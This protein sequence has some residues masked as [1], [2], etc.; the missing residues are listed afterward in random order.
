MKKVNFIFKFF[1]SPE[2]SRRIW[3]VSLFIVLAAFMSVQDSFAGSKNSRRLAMLRCKQTNPLYHTIIL[4]AAKR[5]DVEP[6]IIKAIILAESDFNPRAVSNR[7]AKGLMQLMPGTAGELG[8]KNI[9]SPEQNI[10]GGVKYFKTLLNS[11]DG[12]IRL[13]LAAY[14]AGSGKVRKYNG[15]PPYKATRYYI[16][17]VM[18]YYQHY[19]EYKGNNTA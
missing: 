4:A 5:Y 17:K 13:A 19:K 15:V 16:K 7:G 8:V 9:Y 3:W 14:N 12:E 18:I 1:K 6:A 10:K 2:H 11:F